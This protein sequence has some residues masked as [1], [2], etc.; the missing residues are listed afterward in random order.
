MK[1]NIIKIWS[2]TSTCQ[3]SSQILPRYLLPYCTEP[4][5]LAAPMAEGRGNI[6][7]QDF[8]NYIRELFSDETWP[9]LLESRETE[10]LLRLP[11]KKCHKVITSSKNNKV[12]RSSADK[13]YNKMMAEDNMVLYETVFNRTYIY[14]SFPVHWLEYDPKNE[15]CQKIQ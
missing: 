15:Q 8:Y 10:I 14:G 2:N 3:I 1:Y 5:S 7:I 11:I 13:N 4:E 12:A 6:F 9:V